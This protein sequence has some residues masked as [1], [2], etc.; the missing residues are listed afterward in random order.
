M[1]ETLKLKINEE[2]FP[3]GAYPAV[4]G[5]FRYNAKR[6]GKAPSLSATLLYPQCLDNE[7]SDDVY[8]EFRGE[9][10]Y[11]KQTPA[12]SYDNTSVMY[13][14]NVEFVSERTVLE[15]VYFFD[16]VKADAEDDKPASNSSTFSFF[17]DLSQ[18]ATRLTYSMQWS[19]L[20][21][22]VVVDADVELEEFHME[23]QD[24]FL[25]SV[26]QKSYEIFKVPYY[27]VGKVIH[28][29]YAENVI[30]EVLRYGC[31]NALMSIS[32]NNAGSAIVNRV[33]GL[34]SDRNITYYYPNPTP[35]G[36]IY[37]GGKARNFYQ[38]TNSLDFANN[39]ELEKSFHCEIG[40]ANLLSSGKLEGN[41]REKD[42]TDYNIFTIDK[43]ER[44]TEYEIIVSFSAKY[45]GTASTYSQIPL[46]LYP[47][48][49]GNF[50]NLNQYFIE[51]SLTDNLGNSWVVTPVKFHYYNEFSTGEGINYYNKSYTLRLKY[52][53]HTTEYISVEIV[54][55][56]FNSI[57][58][59]D[60]VST[61]VNIADD[62]T[63]KTE[64]EIP[65]NTPGRIFIDTKF[66]HLGK[67]A[68]SATKYFAKGVVLAQ[69]EEIGVAS[70]ISD[71]LISCGYLE[72]GSYT[73]ECSFYPEFPFTP[74]N[75]EVTT[76]IVEKAV[77]LYDD[78]DIYL[79][80]SKAGIEPVDGRLPKNGDA[81]EQELLKRVNVQNN[82]MP[83]I[84]RE[85]D[86]EQRFY[87]AENEVY[88]D[89]DGNDIVFAN[90]YSTTRPREY[91][92][93]DDEIYPSIEGMVNANGLRIDMFSEF[94]FDENDNDD[95]YPVGHEREGKYKHPYFFGKLRKF[96]G[97]HG[98]N[99]FDH[100]I[101]GQPM[102]ISMKSG[103]C[104]ACNFTIGVDEET[105]SYNTVQ[106]TETDSI[107]VN[108]TIPAGT[109]KRDEEGNVLCGRWP[110]APQQKQ[111]Q[112]NDTQ[113]YEVWIALKKDIQTFGVVMPNA[114][115]A[116]RPSAGDQFVIL[117]IDLPEAYVTAAEDRLEKAIIDYMAENNDYKFNFSVKFSRI[118]FEENPDIANL[119]NENA[120]VTLEYN[121]VERDLYVSS[122]AYSA[123]ANDALPEV[124]IELSDD[125][126]IFK[127]SIQKEQEQLYKVIDFNYNILS[128]KDNEYIKFSQKA[129]ATAKTASAT[130][131]TALESSTIIKTDLKVVEA[132]ATEAKTLATIAQ[133]TANKTS[134]GL[135][136]NE[137]ALF[138]IDK[139]LQEVENNTGSIDISELKEQVSTNTTNID[140]LVKA[141]A[142]MSN[143]ISALTGRLVV[144]E[145][146]QEEQGNLIVTVNKT[147]TSLTNRVTNVEKKVMIAVVSGD[148]ATEGTLIVEDDGE[149]NLIVS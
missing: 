110:Q 86:G 149:G 107:T 63:V 24:Q 30:G 77:W 105:S 23:L 88:K 6:M 147:V 19:G 17:G 130:A 64:L 136:A 103:K 67:P 90:P 55:D 13:R 10:Y 126:K 75:T 133:T 87:N 94:A 96:D 118:F 129:E 44:Y 140:T 85:T 119:I 108:G 34:G 33:T 25:E 12:S 66:S 11:L 120:K 89:D 70:V 98:F 124:T 82:L 38:V 58:D 74:Q 50:V 59:M 100:A 142:T 42:S 7:W 72:P 78:S 49:D 69:D 112:Q 123:S 40:K 138:A 148:N 101:E 91:I 115:N 97:E 26:L 117:N 146:E 137:K 62:F 68:I 122:F 45:A 141:D 71:G 127:S 20:D 16:V 80:L 28:F 135:S 2:V 134:E 99:L 113:N 92:F 29:G 61:V 143:N 104:G 95:I 57:V 76:E 84:Y 39:V 41:Y 14:H 132:Q 145:E 52:G 128:T 116:Y 37:L 131:Q 93:K 53:F 21:Y 54:R 51:G 18:L 3:N 60:D 144:V 27:F 31:D 46:R 83:S 125:I 139:R 47:L 35:K 36:T 9:R 121:G 43:T 4:I 106:V 102:T 5:D 1:T 65:E 114:T 73:V 48:I 22:S 15:S 8:V 81:L 79:D 56:D 32:K 111:A 109:L